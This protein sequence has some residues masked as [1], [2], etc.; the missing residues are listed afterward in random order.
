MKHAIRPGFLKGRLLWLEEN[1]KKEGCY[2]IPFDIIVAS[3]RN[4][5]LPHAKPTE[6]K[7]KPGDL[8]VVDWG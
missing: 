6:K 7:I 8:V 4:S 3:G 5:A 1:L 2:S